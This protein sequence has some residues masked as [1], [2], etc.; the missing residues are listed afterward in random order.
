MSSATDA[1][2]A[3]NAWVASAKPGERHEYYRGFLAAQRRDLEGRGCPL[4][5]LADA[6]L[7]NAQLGTVDLCQ[8]RH[9]SCDYTYLAVARTPPETVS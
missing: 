8:V 9:A 2:D 7:H 5:A 4:G 3:F 1:W 6:A